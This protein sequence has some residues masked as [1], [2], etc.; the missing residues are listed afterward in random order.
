MTAFDPESKINPFSI[1]F[2]KKNDLETNINVEG[3]KP[4]GDVLAKTGG[5][6]SLEGGDY[7]IAKIFYEE[8]SV[9]EGIAR[10][11]NLSNF[12]YEDKS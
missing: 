1:F 8:K 9:L 11:S 3:F 12:S 4:F 2:E 5:N 6:I 10:L 7:T